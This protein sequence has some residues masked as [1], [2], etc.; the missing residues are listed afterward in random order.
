MEIT[1]RNARIEDFDAV[2]RIIETK[3]QVGDPDEKDY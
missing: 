2:T 3:N 1:I